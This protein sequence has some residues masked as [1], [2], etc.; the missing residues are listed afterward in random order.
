[1]IELYNCRNGCSDGMKSK[2]GFT[3]H[4]VTCGFSTL[5]TRR[6]TEPQTQV[7]WVWFSIVLNN[8][9]SAV[10]ETTHFSCRDGRSNKTV[11]A[12]VAGHHVALI[13]RFYFCDEV[14]QMLCWWMAPH[15]HNVATLGYKVF[16]K[17]VI[18]GSRKICS[19]IR[20]NTAQSCNKEHYCY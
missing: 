4:W 1:M 11:A 10:I 13:L 15:Y 2:P 7:W 18:Y 5:Q 12:M 8:E 19:H 16:I 9:S 3:G 14:L 17:T 6:C 20:V